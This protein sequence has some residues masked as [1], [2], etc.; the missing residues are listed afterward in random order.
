MTSLWQFSLLEQAEEMNE[1]FL[2]Q[3]TSLLKNHE[4]VIMEDFNYLDICWEYNSAKSQRSS[5]FVSSLGDN[6]ICQKMEKKKKG[7][8]G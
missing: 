2:H 3:M 8:L 5:T 4:I 1:A 7:G 6:F